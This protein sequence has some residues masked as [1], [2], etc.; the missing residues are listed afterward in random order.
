MIMAQPS[1]H[2]WQDNGRGSRNFSLKKTAWAF[3]HVGAL[4]SSHWLYGDR[5]TENGVEFVCIANDR[6][7]LDSTRTKLFFNHQSIWL[8]FFAKFLILD[9]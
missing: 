8:H 4:L 7:T 1:S 5:V 9:P 6:K 2:G 3:S